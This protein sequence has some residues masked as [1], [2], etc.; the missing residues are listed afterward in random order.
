MAIAPIPIG[1]A[2]GERRYLVPP[3]VF[4]AG[5]MK[6]G[7]GPRDDDRPVSLEPRVELLPQGRSDVGLDLSMMAR[8]TARHLVEQLPVDTILL[9]VLHDRPEEEE[10]PPVIGEHP[11]HD[12]LV[13]LPAM[14]KVP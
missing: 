2:G 12:R 10:I 14:A 9:Q 1:E 5:I 6:D 4:L 11:T 3:P 8:E 13:F 7:P